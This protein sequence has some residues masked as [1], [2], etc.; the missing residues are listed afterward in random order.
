MEHRLMRCILGFVPVDPSKRGDLERER[1]L[2]QLA[3]LYSSGVSTQH[4]A[5]ISKESILHITRRVMLGYI[6]RIKT[7]ILCFDLWPRYRT[8]TKGP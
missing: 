7:E 6:E 8:K 3:S 2:C 4:M 1:S 5:G